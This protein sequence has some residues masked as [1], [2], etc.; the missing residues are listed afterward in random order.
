MVRCSVMILLNFTV[1]LT[2]YQPADHP[3][4]IFISHW[5]VVLL[6]SHGAALLTSDDDVSHHRDHVACHL[7]HLPHNIDHLPSHSDHLPLL[8]VPHCSPVM[9]TEK[10]WCVHDFWCALVTSDSD[11]LH[12]ACIYAAMW[13]LP[14]ESISS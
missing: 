13:A 6:C 4:D 7:D 9:M 10:M 14:I 11:R 1:A 5:R 2:P 8:M 12:H 3:Q